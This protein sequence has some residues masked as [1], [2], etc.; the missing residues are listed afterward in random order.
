MLVEISIP[1]LHE[2]GRFPEYYNHNTR[3]RWTA[4]CPLVSEHKDGH[5]I[6]FDTIFVLLEA[7]GKDSISGIARCENPHCKGLI[8]Y[9]VQK[10]KISA[11]QK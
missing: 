5:K 1:E 6:P 3:Q 8:H 11:D 2:I 10:I 7:S 9:T 4:E